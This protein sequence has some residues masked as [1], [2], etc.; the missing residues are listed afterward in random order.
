MLM[1]VIDLADQ[2]IDQAIKAKISDIHLESSVNV[3]RI[4]FRLDGKLYLERELNKDKAQPLMI[5]LKV[6][7]GMDIADMRHPQDGQLKYKFEDRYIDLRLAT[8]PT[9]HGEKMVIRILDQAS[10]ILSVDKLMLPRAISKKL[11]AEI[12]RSY[13]LF[14]V[15]G[16]TGSGK[17]TTLYALLQHINSL[18]KNIITIEDP[19]EYQLEN[20]NQIQVNSKAGITF[21]TGLRAILRQ[22]P[23]V[24]LVGEIRDLE[25][26]EIALRAA[27][28]GHLVLGTLHTRDALEAIVRLQDMGIPSFRISSALRVVLAQRLIPIYCTACQGAGCLLCQNTGYKGRRAIFEYL[29]L[30]PKIQETINKTVGYNQLQEIARLECYQPLVL[31]SR[32]LLEKKITSREALGEV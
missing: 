26:A 1:N 5:R 25:T 12:R 7:C 30:T 19:I 6:M 11:L 18:E 27:L 4:R 2:I 22:D 32:E 24:I 28:T 15:V 29:E 20:I 31:N 3:L 10:G 23:D 17:T 9:V 8:I 13:G 21:A 14:L 16:P